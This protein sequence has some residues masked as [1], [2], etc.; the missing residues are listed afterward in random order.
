MSPFF[1]GPRLVPTP[2]HVL[3]AESRLAEKRA[4]TAEAALQH[5]EADLRLYGAV[6]ETDSWK[7]PYGPDTAVFGSEPRARDEQW[8][9][10]TGA[11]PAA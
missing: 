2:E 10:T 7:D 8:L 1:R 11:S 5:E 4:R 3:E 6:S 9:G